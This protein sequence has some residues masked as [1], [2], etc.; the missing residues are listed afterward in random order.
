MCSTIIDVISVFSF[1]FSYL[2]FKQIQTLGQ[3]L[4]HLV[5]AP[6]YRDITSGAS[7][8]PVTRQL[9]HTYLYYWRKGCTG[10]KNSNM[11]GL[12]FSQYYFSNSVRT[13]TQN[14]QLT[15]RN[16]QVLVYH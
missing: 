12:S 8:S 6:K 4:T 1:L 14:I 3:K 10:D 5:P 9:V 15:K 16:I 13:E 11:Y 2:S 7:E